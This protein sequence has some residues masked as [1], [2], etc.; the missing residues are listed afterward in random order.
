MAGLAGDLPLAKSALV[1]AL[2][3][4][5]DLSL[6]WIERYY[7]MAHAGRRALYAEGLRHAGLS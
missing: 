1:E 6:E 7:P 4:Q 3:M 2:R 5:P